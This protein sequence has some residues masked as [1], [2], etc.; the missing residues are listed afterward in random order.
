MNLLNLRE[1]SWRQ[2]AWLIA[3]VVVIG[4]LATHP[5]LRIFIPLIDVMGLDL[6]LLVLGSQ[7]WEHARPLLLIVF[8]RVIRPLAAKL[9]PVMLF[10]FGYAG[11]YVD[12]SVRTCNW[13]SAPA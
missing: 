3:T 4:L 10:F 1:M 6:L 13:R 11:N 5:D 9:Y 12:A 2:R 7:L 8:I